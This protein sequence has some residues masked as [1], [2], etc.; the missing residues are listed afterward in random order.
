MQL[1]HLKGGFTIRSRSL[2]KCSLS[3]SSF[4][5]ISAMFS[6]PGM[7]SIWICLRCILSLTALSRSCMCRIVRVV[8]FFDHCTQAMLS[9]WTSVGDFMNV[10]RKTRLRNTL[11]RYM[12]SL[13]H[14]SVAY[15]SA[16]AELLAVID[17]RLHCQWRG[18]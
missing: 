15:I 5:K 11:R 18:P 6:D 1:L 10:S 4:V 2:Q 17:C 12:S 3:L 13:T 16:S 8:L 7:C 14:S 9:L